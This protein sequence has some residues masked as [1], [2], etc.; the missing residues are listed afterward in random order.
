MLRRPILREYE[1][2][3]LANSIVS[4]ANQIT[5]EDLYISI[6]NNKVVLKSKNLNK[7]IIPCL[8]NAHNYS[9]DSVPIYHFLCDLQGQSVHPIPSF[10]WG[11]LESHHD[12]FPRVIYADV[13][14]S[15]AK[16]LLVYNELEQFTKQ[17]FTDEMFKEFKLWKEKK[18][19]P[20]YV[21]LVNGDNTLLLDLNLQIGI[22]L[23]L[24]TIKPNSKIILEEF[25][26]DDNSIV[27]DADSNSFANQFIL[28]FYKSNTN[29]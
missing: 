16:W 6:R 26:F 18:R 11:I 1:I 25:L 28:S 2:P 21:N 23:L 17:E 4:K 19:L 5:I 13:I 27:K 12:Y 22:T 3:Y 15:K 9:Y 7:E 10:S 14:L 20:Q 29:E 24:K 8:S